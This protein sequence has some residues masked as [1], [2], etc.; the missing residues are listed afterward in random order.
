ML[1][2]NAVIEHVRLDTPIYM[3]GLSLVASGLP[4]AFESLGL[5]WDRFHNNESIPDT[6]D[7]PVEIG[8]SI[9]NKD[10]LVGCQTFIQGQGSGLTSFTIPIGN[11]I[12]GGFSADSFGE[13]VDERLQTIWEDISR[14]AGEHGIVLSDSFSVEVYPQ[15]TVS[16]ERPEMYCLCPIKGTDL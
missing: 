8:V 16:L 7:P 10:Y 6:V 3:T 12:K 4:P 13:L 11:Y 2:E 1:T 9:N 15:N 14:W 5:L